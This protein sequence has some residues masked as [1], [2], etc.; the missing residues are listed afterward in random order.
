MSEEK[1]LTDEIDDAWLK[2]REDWCAANINKHNAAGYAAE[3]MRTMC[4]R[5]RAD[6][7]RIARL[8]KAINE[9]VNGMTYR[10]DTHDTHELIAEL[11][12]ALEDK[13]K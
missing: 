9:A 8:E 10:M 3:L 13:T 7:K 2:R 12:A 6:R 4:A 5:I 11:R 1:P